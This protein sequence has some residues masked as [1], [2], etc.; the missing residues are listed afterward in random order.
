MASI[1]LQDLTRVYP[2]AVPALTDCTFEVADGSF[3]V[4]LGPSGCG[5]STALRLVAGLELPD[6]GRVLIG[7]RDVTTT[8]PG[9]RNLAMV[10]Q[11]YALYP[12]LTVR[13]NLAFPLRMRRVPAV[14]RGPR[15]R[16][17]AE[18][19]GLAD[20]LERH[21]AQLSGGQRQRVALGRALVREPE[22]FLLDEPLSNLDAALRSELRTE[23]LRV[24][25]QLHATMLYVTHDQVEALTMADRIVVLREGRVEQQG[26]PAELYDRPA[27]TFVARFLGTPGMNLL[28]LDVEPAGTALVPGPGP[29]GAAT[30]GLRPEALHLG[31]DGAPGAVT[32]VERLGSETLVHLAIGGRVVVARVPGQAPLTDGATV[33]VT[34]D[35]AQLHWFDAAGRRLP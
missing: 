1:T 8:P 2:P 31:P 21:P 24:Q 23:L 12:H 19:L 7:R 30:C 4:L 13:E 18:L 6:R 26:T 5:K 33:G 9:D 14:D 29:A 25:R 34:A 32:L 11:N 10:F 27:T 17:V 22:A 16:R 20:L 15:I 3:V 35:P 28:P